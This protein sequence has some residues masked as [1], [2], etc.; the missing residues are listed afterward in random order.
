MPTI[1]PSAATALG[2]IGTS[3]GSPVVWN[4]SGAATANSSIPV[5]YR[6]SVRE[7]QAWSFTSDRVNGASGARTVVHIQMLPQER[8]AQA[9]T[10]TRDCCTSPSGTRVVVHERMLPMPVDSSPLGGFR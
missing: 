9:F 4:P 2:N 1:S 8:D 6:G 3:L 10:F 7:A 5:G